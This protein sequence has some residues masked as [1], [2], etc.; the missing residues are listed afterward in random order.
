MLTGVLKNFSH[1]D[2][3]FQLQPHD[4]GICSKEGKYIYSQYLPYPALVFGRRAGRTF[5]EKPQVLPDTVQVGWCITH[6]LSLRATTGVRKGCCQHLLGRLLLAC[7]AQHFREKY[8]LTSQW[9]R[10]HCIGHISSEN[11]ERESWGISISLD[12]YRLAILPS[13]SA[14]EI[15]PWVMQGPHKLC[16]L[17]MCPH[18]RM[19][20]EVILALEMLRKEILPP[21]WCHSVVS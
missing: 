8:V 15:I 11:Q 18:A 20:E 19:M 7:Y 1:L 4:T 9:L 3:K 14:L 21:F 6:V 5:A 16:A 10:I 2:T 17:H 12:F 13:A